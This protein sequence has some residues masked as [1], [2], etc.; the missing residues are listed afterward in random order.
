VPFTEL[1]KA[2]EKLHPDIDILTEGHGSIQ[3]IRHVTELD[4]EADIVAVADYS[5]IAPMMYE[6]KI[7]D[8]D[9]AYADWYLT[10]ATNTLGLAY[11]PQSRYADEIN[12]DNWYEILSRPDVNLGI[13][14]PRFDACGYR[15]LM[16][17]QLAESFYA[18]DNILEG[19]IGNFS[20]PITVQSDNGVTVI[21]VP[22][23][24]K[25]DKI[26]IRG[27]SVVLLGILE[28]GDIDY[29]FEYKSVAQQHDLQF[30]ELPA[31]INLG[32]EDY[33]NLGVEISVILDYQRFATVN[34]EFYCQQIIYGITIPSTAIN[35]NAAAD[36][37]EFL[38]GPEGQAI[39]A[40]NSQPMIP[41]SG[42][43]TA[44]APE[45]VQQ[46]IDK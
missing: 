28:S 11:T 13:S 3:V 25:P 9:K 46:L 44:N 40:E 21:L 31:E 1:E 6:V 26:S 38:L 4:E 33:L 8:S 12:S 18:D 24:L 42:D 16:V 29:A 34:P 10:F 43:N 27:S 39:L 30:L 20:Y 45:S 19:V 14:D 35:P 7:A 41:L 17:C 5:L 2:Y 32:S 37:L 22:E 15:S 23:V 36:Y